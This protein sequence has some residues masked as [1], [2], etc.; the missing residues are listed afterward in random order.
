[1]SASEPKLTQDARGLSSGTLAGLIGSTRCDVIDAVQFDF[2]EFCQ[3]N[4]HYETWV[5][6]WEDFKKI[7]NFVKV[8]SEKGM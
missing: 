1:M 2:I 6:A 5:A 7:Y 3:E 4:P 8:I